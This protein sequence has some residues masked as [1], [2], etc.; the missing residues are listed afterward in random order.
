MSG[1]TVTFPLVLLVLILIAVSWVL[2]F[3]ARGRLRPAQRQIPDTD[4]FTGLN[5]LLNDEPD[6][7]I[8][9]FIDA[10]EMG[11]STFDTH[12][13]LGKLLRRRGK[14]DRSIAHYESLLASRR[15]NARQ[16]A[17]L[18][19]QLLRSY[20]AAG[21]LDRA[22]RLLGE[23][24]DSSPSLRIEALRMAVMLYQMEKD[25]TPALDAAMEQLKLVPQQHRHDLLV[26]IS[27]FHCEL[28]E[29]ALGR[30]D[31]MQA[32]H[33]VRQAL[34]LYKGNARVYLVQARIDSA[35]GDHEQAQA[36]L[37]KAVGVEPQ[38]FAEI[39]PELKRVLDCAGIPREALAAPE[40]ARELDRD[41]AYQLE[42]AHQK[43]RSE[44]ASAAIQHLL[45]ALHAVPSLSLLEQTMCLALREQ[46]GHAA[47]LSAAVDVLSQQLQS[48]P[49]FRCEHC[50]FELRNMHWACPGCSSWGVVKPINAVTV[51]GAGTAAATY[52]EVKA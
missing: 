4:Y 40:L 50:G 17:E 28:A 21:L 23:L 52:P 46:E 5:Y 25:W 35:A 3:R 38:L 16:N 41:G 37:Y 18:S 31:L 12:L 51:I 45:R 19:I 14:V 43:C 49:R 8:D 22:E 47:V 32:R 34:A 15:F 42:I 44:G 48:H 39:L 10:L 9:V 36:A 26:Q 24:R 29:L 30:N 27:H 1:D 7:A 33:E 13:A 6:D 2:G 20:I 11:S